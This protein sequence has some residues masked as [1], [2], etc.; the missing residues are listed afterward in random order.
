VPAEAPA[1]AERFS[2]V[3]QVIVQLVEEKEAL[4]PVGNDEVVNDTAVGL[5]VSSV[6]EM[7]S[8]PDCPCVTDRL[9]AAESEKVVG[10]IEPAE[11]VNV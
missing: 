8:V 7:V 3:L 10:T 6:A 9:G 2:D 5:P 1:D 4:T 11:V